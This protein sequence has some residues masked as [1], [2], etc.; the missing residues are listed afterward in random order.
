MDIKLR[1]KKVDKISL[2]KMSNEE[3]TQMVREASK[4]VNPKYRKLGALVNKSK[5]K[6]YTK[7]TETGGAISIKKAK[8]RA[9]EKSEKNKANTL[10]VKTIN[11]LPTTERGK[12]II[13]NRLRRK[14]M[15]PEEKA[16]DIRE[17][18]RIAQKKRREKARAEKKAAEPT[19][20]MLKEELVSEVLRAAEFLKS[21]ES[22]P[23]GFE[24]E[25]QRKKKIFEKYN[26]DTEEQMGEILTIY[27]R[28]REMEPWLWD[29]YDSDQILTAITVIEKDGDPWRWDYNKLAI[30]V[31]MEIKGM[32]KW[33]WE[34]AEK[35]WSGDEFEMGEN[36]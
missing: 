32:R 15:T 2:S 21:K 13:Q 14:N 25:E 28:L 9:A 11:K 26:I 4:I 23:S 22:T 18:R 12:K 19:E 3:L 36:I 10:R 7:L 33:F 17:Q 5:N 31:D 30:L 35:D 24:K 20:E 29:L 34:Q 16:A 27:N 6:A 1:L 8:Q